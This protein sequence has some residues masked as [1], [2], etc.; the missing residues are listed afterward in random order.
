MSKRFLGWLQPD[1][2][3]KVLDM[4][5]DHLELTLQTVIH[6]GE[7]VEASSDNNADQK[8]AH[9]KELSGL[10]MR[11][12]EL[13]RKIIEELTTTKLSPEERDDLMELVRSVDWIA[14]WSKEAGR[15]LKILPYQSLNDELKADST[16]MVNATIN[17]VKILV[18]A[19]EAL[20]H[21]PS[22]ALSLADEVEML[23]ETV[24]DLFAEVRTHFAKDD[25]PG[26]SFNALVLLNEFYTAVETVAD[27]CENTADVVRAVGVRRH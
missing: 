27:W 20:I 21:E 10:E 18:S 14:D 16:H 13:R 23:E 15:I 25:F 12:D 3:K 9:Y 2:R 22:K 8:D 6:L 24:D 26:F 1:E 4:V 11:A 17:C 5:Q 19:I 7:M